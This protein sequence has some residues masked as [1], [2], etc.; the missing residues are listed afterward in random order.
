MAKSITIGPYG[1]GGVAP[2]NATIKWNP[3]VVQDEILLELFD[4]LTIG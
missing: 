3:G 1:V 4:G 2:T